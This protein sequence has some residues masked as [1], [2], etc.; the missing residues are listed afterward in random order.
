MDF[1]A[2]FDQHHG[3]HSS[4]MRLTVIDA[5]HFSL[6]V[7]LI[8]QDWIVRQSFSTSAAL[9]RWALIL[10]RLLVSQSSTELPLYM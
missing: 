7:L 6:N 3:Q 1:L 8:D 4:R 5:A 10:R 2:R 9:I